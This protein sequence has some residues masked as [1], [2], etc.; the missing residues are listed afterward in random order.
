M[1]TGRLL[2][3]QH[4]LIGSFDQ[5]TQPT[6]FYCVQMT[7]ATR[8]YS[9]SIHNL[10][11]TPLGN[12]I[13]AF[14]LPEPHWLPGQTLCPK[15]GI[16]RTLLSFHPRSLV[17][18]RNIRSLCFLLGIPVVDQPESGLELAP[19]HLDSDPC[20]WTKERWRLL[21]PRSVAKYGLDSGCDQ[22]PVQRLGVR[23]R[24]KLRYGH[25]F[26][27]GK[28]TPLRGKSKC[29]RSILLV[30]QFQVFEARAG[31]RNQPRQNARAAVRFTLN[32]VRRKAK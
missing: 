4:G 31:R 14:L 9:T 25:S 17:G 29:Y 11:T 2:T 27:E 22:A 28:L 18:K 32:S 5:G 21:R 15:P 7:L 30:S 16:V 6:V 10:F 13:V 1:T 26:H 19:R 23:R 24:V 8:R 20:A 12:A 3:A